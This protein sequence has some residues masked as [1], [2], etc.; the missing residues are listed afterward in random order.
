MYQEKK[1]ASVYLSW[2][3]KSFLP[4]P[5]LYLMWALSKSLLYV[6]DNSDSLSSKENHVYK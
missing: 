2:N 5:G 6:V 1:K 3:K 4:T